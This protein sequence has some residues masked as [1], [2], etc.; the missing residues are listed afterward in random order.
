[1]SG[2]GGVG[3]WGVVGFFGGGGGGFFFFF[4][5]FPLMGPRLRRPQ[6]S[7]CREMGKTAR[8]VHC[9]A[10]GKAPRALHMQGKGLRRPDL[11]CKID[12]L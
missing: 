5:L 1:M 6:L 7:T 11:Q 8:A 9:R 2:W 4:F 10:R 12:F 3:G